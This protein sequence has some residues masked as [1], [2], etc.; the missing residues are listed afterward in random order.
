MTTLCYSELGQS[1]RWLDIPV[2]PSPESAQPLCTGADVTP[3]IPTASAHPF[4][5]PR[6]N[7]VPAPKGR[8][9]L[10]GPE[11][12]HRPGPALLFEAL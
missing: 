2:T 9:Q 3:G 4:Q 7:R 12:T 5:E 6:D 1:I 8:A 11:E 10:V